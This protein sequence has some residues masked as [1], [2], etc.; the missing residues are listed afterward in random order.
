MC[1]IPEKDKPLEAITPQAGGAITGVYVTLRDAEDCYVLVHI[2]QAVATAVDITIEQA[3]DVEGTGS[4]VITTAVP[5]WADQDCASSDALLRQPD[6]V[7]FTTSATLAHKLV[8]FQINPSH[9]DVT[10]G[11]DCITV[12]TA[13]SDP[14]NITAAQY[15]LSDLRFGGSTPP[16]DITD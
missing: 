8:V 12:K 15:I 9:L 11:F 5:I 1:C 4:K 14:T 13:A 7:A 3:T 2:N 10:N 16:T 6:A